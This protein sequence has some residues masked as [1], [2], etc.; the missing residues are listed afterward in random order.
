MPEVNNSKYS[1]K[2]KIIF[3]FLPFFKEKKDVQN[4]VI[5]KPVIIINLLK[6]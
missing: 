1:W 3:I 6:I 2:N 4:D 5:N